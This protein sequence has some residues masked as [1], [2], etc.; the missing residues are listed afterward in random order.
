MENSTMQRAWKSMPNVPELQSIPEP[1]C[2]V[3]GESC[4]TKSQVEHAS[5]FPDLLRD[6]YYLDAMYFTGYCSTV[7]PD[8]VTYR[9]KICE[10]CLKKM[11]RQ[12]FETDKR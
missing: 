4:W 5:G 8:G 2:N 7:L 11:F 1:I 12:F 6:K 3:C 9:F 10:P